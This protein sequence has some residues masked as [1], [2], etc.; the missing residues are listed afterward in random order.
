MSAKIQAVPRKVCGIC[1]LKFSEICCCAPRERLNRDLLAE[2]GKASIEIKADD[3]G[4]NCR[5]SGWAYTR[6]REGRQTA[7]QKAPF[8]D[9]A[10][11][12]VWNFSNSL[13]D[14]ACDRRSMFATCADPL[15]NRTPMVLL[16]MAASSSSR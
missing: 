16:A 5:L 9:V 6:G 12:G 8:A 14:C 1:R 15:M 3:R 4:M 11:D 13:P 2:L 10:A 7:F